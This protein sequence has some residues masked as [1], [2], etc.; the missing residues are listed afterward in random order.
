MKTEYNIKD[1][2]WI[3]LGEYT[4]TEGRVVEIITLDHLKENHRP[5]HELYVIEIKT[6][7]DDV[8]EVRDFDHISPDAK[9]PIMFFRN[10]K[11]DVQSANRYLKK[12]GILLP[13]GKPNTALY[14]ND[15]DDD[16][17]DG[18]GS[19]DE[20]TTEQIHA[21]MERAT[22]KD[23]IFN[24]TLTKAPAKKPRNRNFVKRKK[25]DNINSNT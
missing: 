1:K 23:T 22:A 20:P 2:V 25:N 17:H 21:A 15:F 11:T 6:G 5:G 14:I 24:P 3:H 7:I 4:L 12:I 13:D 9:G 19:I 16:G 8:Y 10:I 18:L